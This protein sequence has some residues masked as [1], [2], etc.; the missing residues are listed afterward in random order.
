[1]LNFWDFFQCFHW[2]C[3]VHYNCYTINLSFRCQRSKKIYEME[4]AMNLPVGWKRGRGRF[5]TFITPVGKLL[6]GCS[7]AI[8]ELSETKQSDHYIQLLRYLSDN[9]IKS[10]ISAFSQ[11]LLYF[12][13][14]GLI[15]GVL[16]VQLEQGCDGASCAWRRS[17]VST[18]GPLADFTSFW[19]FKW[20]FVTIW[21]SE[22]LIHP[23]KKY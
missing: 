3:H 20:N 19:I 21:N 2:H 5:P 16:K 14:I 6:R 13:C 4:K 1:M 7:N 22:V 17:W 11:Y 18:L 8:L 9:F 23:C 15:V 12:P 10:C